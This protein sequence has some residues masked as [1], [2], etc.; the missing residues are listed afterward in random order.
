MA[1]SLRP[2]TG[3]ANAAPWSKASSIAS[4]MAAT[5]LLAARTVALCDTAKSRTAPPCTSPTLTLRQLRRLASVLTSASAAADSVSWSPATDRMS[6]AKEARSSADRSV[7]GLAA[8]EH[9]LQPARPPMN[10]PQDVCPI[11][12]PVDAQID[13]DHRVK[14][15]ADIDWI[16][17]MLAE[18]RVRQ[19]RP[20]PVHKPAP[21]PKREFCGGCEIG[22]IAP[23]VRPGRPHFV[24]SGLFLNKNK[25]SSCTFYRSAKNR[26]PCG[27]E[28][29]AAFGTRKF[30]P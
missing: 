16:G 15:S 21:L 10:L 17:R 12:R 18:R 3:S 11:G 14:M 9:G 28:L 30:F 19:V 24:L 8:S 20:P 7:L 23:A 2:N 26:Q 29:N 1:R 22:E 4:S 5:I 13:H 6:R 27:A 25:R